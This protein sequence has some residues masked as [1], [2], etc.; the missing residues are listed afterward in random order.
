MRTAF[1]NRFGT[2]FG[3]YRVVSRQLPIV[4][5]HKRSFTSQT[6]TAAFFVNS[7]QESNNSGVHFEVIGLWNMHSGTV[8][9]EM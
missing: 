4:P 7:F 5:E 9:K 6:V 2:K 1:S 3:I 8:L